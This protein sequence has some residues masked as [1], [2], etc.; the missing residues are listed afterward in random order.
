MNLRKPDLLLGIVCFAVA[1]LAC[2]AGAQAADDSGYYLGGGIGRSRAANMGDASA[3]VDT[4]LASQ[5]I[6]SSTSFGSADTAWKLFGGYQFTR[7][8]GLEGGLT[9]LG[10]FSGSSAISAPV[11]DS[12]TGTW[13]A[14]NVLSLAAIG[15][16]PLG[17]EFSAF[18]KLGLAYS[19]A[20]LSYA[21]PVSGASISQ[22][23]TQTTPLIG[24]GLK[25]DL[26]KHFAVRGEWERYM[27]LGDNST[28]GRTDVNAWT[29]SLQRRF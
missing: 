8:L 3:A 25:Y 26:D 28:S 27:G 7:Y 14:G 21:A 5:G 22:S 10:R 13:K 20:D 18:G 11:P 29:A 17:N 16:L 19:R 15:S 2:A 4:S 23:S 9:D 1:G 6:G 24:L 12:G